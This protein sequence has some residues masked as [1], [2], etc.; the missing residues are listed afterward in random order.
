[1]PRIRRTKEEIALDIHQQHKTC[2]VCN[3][4][5]HFNE[6]FNYKNKNDNKSYRCKECDSKARNNWS[7]NNPK[8]AYESMR[9]R[10]LKQRFGISLDDYIRMFNDQG[11]KCAICGATENNTTGDRK[12]WNFA[13]D[14]DH[15]TGKVRGILCNNCNRGLGLLR[16]S[17]E[18]LRKAALYVEEHR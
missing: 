10:N 12:D 17:E 13:V 6:F 3:E 1:M 11:C 18:L 9:G 4:R 14:H 16:D 5:K 2:C 8:K 15:K 7:L